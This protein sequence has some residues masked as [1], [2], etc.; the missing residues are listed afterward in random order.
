MKMADWVSPLKSVQDVF[1]SFFINLRDISSFSFGSIFH[2]GP[3]HETRESG[4]DISTV[5]RHLITLCVVERVPCLES[6]VWLVMSL[7]D[8]GTV[9]NQ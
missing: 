1:L 5:T 8:C 3:L 6:A 7:A 9:S 2:L 4:A